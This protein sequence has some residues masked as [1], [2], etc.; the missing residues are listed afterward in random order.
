M[1]LS[2]HLYLKDDKGKTQQWWIN[3]LTDENTGA[4]ITDIAASLSKWK[5]KT[6]I[7]NSNSDVIVFDTSEAKAWFLLH[8]L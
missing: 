8:Y 3:F 2:H 6:Y 4:R 5:A 7:D 1:E